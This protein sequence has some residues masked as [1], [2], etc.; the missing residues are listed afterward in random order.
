MAQYTIKT[1]SKDNEYYT[2]PQISGE[3]V[4]WN[5]K[6][7]DKS[8]IFLDDG[9]KT[10]EIKSASAYN[11][12]PPLIS[13]N[14]VVWLGF[15]SDNNQQLFM[16]N[17]EKTVRLTDGEDNTPLGLS[18]ISGDNIVWGSNPGNRGY[19]N[20]DIYL[21]DGKK[22][23]QLTN[24][25]VYDSSPRISGDRVV[26]KGGS[27]ASNSEIYLYDG[28]KITQ[29]T[30]DNVFDSSPKI[31]GNNIVWQSGT[32]EQ[33]LFFYDG[34]KTIQISDSRSLNVS[35][36]ISGNNVVWQR[37][38]SNSKSEIFLF[39]GE[40]T[41]QL[42]NDNVYD[43]SPKISGRNIVWAGGSG[44]NREEIYLD[45]E[46]FFYNGSEIIQ[47]TDNDV[48]DLYPAIDGNKIVWQRFEQSETGK[49]SISVMLATLNDTKSS[50]KP[51]SDRPTQIMNTSA[52]AI[53]GLTFIYLLKKLIVNS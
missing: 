23:I 51:Q 19:K 52:I 42:T 26:W 30:D 53:F 44:K 10:T 45:S 17:G 35:H 33:R 39:N 15:D 2:F 13:G 38:D 32:Y 49:P 22:I 40:E 48:P 1:L 3:K 7:Q 24:D 11:P 8:R 20:S 36:Q 9:N 4:V 12:S 28:K 37:I 27:F 31:S 6:N 46:I 34:R 18:Q 41:I 21:Y 5:E 50:S 43:S 29:L 47:L 16:Y 25:D 14:N